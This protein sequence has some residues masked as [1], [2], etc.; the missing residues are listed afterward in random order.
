MSTYFFRQIFY[1][2]PSINLPWGYESCQKN[3]AQSVQHR[4]SSKKEKSFR[5]N[6]AFFAKIFFSQPFRIIFAHEKCENF[7]FFREISLQ[8]A[9]QKH[10][11]FS[12][13]RKCESFAK[14]FLEKYRILVNKCK[15]FA[16]KLLKFHQKWLNFKNKKL[17]FKEGF[18]C[19]PN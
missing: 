11:K 3:W 8:S 1:L 18:I 12:R 13:N 17:I 9:S 14:I 7:P 5:E 16:I 19:E 2:E 6:F 15:I 4:V 10:A